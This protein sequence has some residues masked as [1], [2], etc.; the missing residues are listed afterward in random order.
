MDIIAMAVALKKAISQTKDIIASHFVAGTNIEITD[1]PDGTQ[2]I[3]AS[4][5]VSVTDEVA[6]QAISDHE[7]DINNPHSVTKN[8]IGLGNVD[9]TS[10]ADKPISAAAQTV[11]NG[12]QDTISDLAAIRSNASAGAGAAE[13]VTGIN[14]TAN[15]YIEMK[16]GVRE[17][18]SL[19]VPTGNIPTGSVGM[20]FD[21]GLYTYKDGERTSAIDKFVGGAI[22]YAY[23]TCHINANA[24]NTD[25]K[26]Y[27]SSTG[28]GVATEVNNETHYI[29]PI[30]V[31][32]EMWINSED[33]IETKENPSAPEKK[34]IRYNVYRN[35]SSEYT[36]DV[37]GLVYYKGNVAVLNKD[38]EGAV[39]KTA[40]RK[41]N[42]DYHSI[43]VEDT[44]DGVTIVGYVV[45]DGEYYYGDVVHYDWDY[46]K[47][48]EPIYNFTEGATVVNIDIGTAP[49]YEGEYVDS[50]T[51]K[52]YRYVDGTLT[53]QN[54]PSA[55]P[56]ITSYTGQTRFAY[57]GENVPS[58][59]SLTYT[60]W[61]SDLDDTTARKVAGITETGNDYI[62]MGNG[63]TL[64]ISATQPQNPSEGDLWIGG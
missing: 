32:P 33:T 3:N 51:G 16:S 13:V 60:G 18:L 44:G 50:S 7:A 20:G 61:H 21:E 41:G 8:Q 43:N 26:I 54:P 30:V 64:Y 28:V 47:A 57:D 59:I 29:L 22:Q 31:I 37:A 27:G 55:L 53:P 48:N 62:K 42:V 4:G 49:L 9:N 24:V 6:R 58:K 1:N 36:L 39:V 12:K 35:I 34:Y 38:T 2:T 40:T 52:V 10:D 46:V 63:I 15:S 25:Y 14:S 17:Y 45:I 19:T 23:E 56:T 5:E 11:L